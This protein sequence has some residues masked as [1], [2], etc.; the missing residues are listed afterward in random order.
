MKQHRGLIAVLA[1]ITTAL[2][3]AVPGM[4]TAAPL[5]TPTPDTR[6]EVMVAET[7]S[8]AL[9]LTRQAVP[10]ATEIPPTFTPAPTAT[11]TATPEE[12]SAGSTLTKNEDGSMTFI[13]E[14]GKY[15][16]TVPMQWLTV[17]VDQQEFLD[18]WLLPEASN[19][20][21]QRSLGTIEKQDPELFRLFALDIAEEHIDGGF[22][23]NMNF[24]WDQR[25]ELSLPSDVRLKELAATLPESIQGTEVLTTEVLSTEG[26]I[27]YGVIT[28]RTPATTQD[29]AE[30]VLSQKLVYFDLP[31]GT[32]S[33]TLSTTETWQE[34]VTPSFDE[35]LE[36]FKIVE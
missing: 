23:T 12:V 13:D 18:A 4:P 15:Q 25:E 24:L 31:I 35:M 6:L 34:T 29:G 9:E 32:L 21:I 26:G 22:V 3:C 11:I 28:S 1:L 14:L 33:I 19:P 10:T 5:S 36:S 7:V 20:A 30:V 27:S 17:R 16:I 2:A 8:A